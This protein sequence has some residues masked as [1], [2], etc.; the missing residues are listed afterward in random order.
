MVRLSPPYILT[1]EFWFIFTWIASH[2]TTHAR[3][4]ATH[5]RAATPDMRMQAH[6]PAGRVLPRPLGMLK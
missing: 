5:C 3:N 4:H 1:S 2:F 6:L